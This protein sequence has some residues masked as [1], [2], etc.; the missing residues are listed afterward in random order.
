MLI[1]FTIWV[2]I[3]CYWAAC[4][5]KKKKDVIGQQQHFAVNCNIT[6]DIHIDKV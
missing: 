1:Q 4:T 3:R 2:D 6:L 5:K